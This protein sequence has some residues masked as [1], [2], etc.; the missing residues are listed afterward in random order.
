MD[1]TETSTLRTTR[2]ISNSTQLSETELNSENQHAKHKALTLSTQVKQYGTSN[3][4]LKSGH[5]QTIEVIRVLH[6]GDL[7]AIEVKRRVAPVLFRCI[8]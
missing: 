8:G 5:N 3:T 4:A 6:M 2:L 1:K 7:S